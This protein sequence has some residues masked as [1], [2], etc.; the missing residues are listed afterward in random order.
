MVFLEFS[1]RIEEKKGDLTFERLNV[2]VEEGGRRDMCV[3][4]RYASPASLTCPVPPF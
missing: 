1:A 3:A 2:T 4:S